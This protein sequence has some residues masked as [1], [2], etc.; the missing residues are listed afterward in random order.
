MEKAP[1]Y[2]KFNAE[3][4]A[5]DP[6]FQSFML[7]SNQDNISFWKNWIADHPDK[8]PEITQAIQIIDAIYARLPQ[9]KMESEVNRI[10]ASVNIGIKTS[11][12]KYFH[13]WKMRH[14]YRYAAALIFMAISAFVVLS[15]MDDQKNV[16]NQVVSNQIVEKSTGK[17]QK[18][19]ITLKDGT[20]IKLNAESTITYPENFSD[21]VRWVALNGEAFFEVTKNPNHPFIVKCGDFY[22]QVLGTSFNINAYPEINNIEVSLLEGKVKTYVQGQKS[23]DLYLEPDEMASYDIANKS[24]VKST[25]DPQKTISWKD[26]IIHFEEASFEQM[27]RTLERWYDVKFI[28]TNNPGMIRFTGEFKNQSLEDVLQGIS[29]SVGFK[30]RISG[31]KVYINS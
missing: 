23:P 27:K 24:I 28:V 31:K 9:D 8:K 4:F 5:Y 10:T 21:S 29:F 26:G 7:A 25:F 6:S 30:F 20:Q 2:S 22:T 3:E 11:S 14:F 17:G 18:L 13:P 12:Q 16:A 19:T 15:L 1:D